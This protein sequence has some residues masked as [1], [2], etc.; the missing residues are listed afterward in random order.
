M[1]KGGTGDPKWW[2][3]GAF[4]TLGLFLCCP[5]GHLLFPVL[6]G[7]AGE[8]VMVR[9]WYWWGMLPV[10]WGIL[11]LRVT[12][13]WVSVPAWSGDAGTGDAGTR[14]VQGGDAGPGA[15]MLVLG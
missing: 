8:P 9:G 6:R 15:V 7:H 11:V 2:G 12:I 1:S 14:V 5:E 3:W 13:L 10:G 4:G